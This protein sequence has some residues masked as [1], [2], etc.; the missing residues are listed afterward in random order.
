MRIGSRQTVRSIEDKAMEVLKIPSLLMMDQAGKRVA[1]EIEKRTGPFKGVIVVLAGTGNNGGDGMAAARHLHANGYDVSVFLAGEEKSLSDN[2]KLY[3][4]ILKKSGVP[5]IS[6]V[7]G[8]AFSILEDN[9]RKTDIVVDALA[10]IGLRGSLQPLLKKIIFC[11]NETDALKVAVDIP[12]GVNANTGEADNAFESDVTVTFILPK[13]GL[14][15][16]PGASFAGNIVLDTLSLPKGLMPKEEVD[17]FLIDSRVAEELIMPRRENSHKG[18]HGKTLI[19]AGSKTMPGAALIAAL[20]ALRAGSGLVKLAM[21]K[22]AWMCV[23]YFPEVIPVFL[24]D[25]GSG[26]LNDSGA[27]EIFKEISESDTVAIGPGLTQHSEVK[28]LIKKLI[29]SID[30]PMVI[31][32]DGLNALAGETSKLNEIDYPKVLTPHP[33]EMARL[34][35]VSTAEIQSDRTSYALKAAEKW[36]AVVVLKGAGTVVASPGGRVFINTTGNPGMAAGG[37]GD[38]LTGMIAGLIG[39]GYKEEEAAVLSVYVH[40]KT[41]DELARTKGTMGLTPSET[42]EM[43]PH[44]LHNLARDFLKQEKGLDNGKVY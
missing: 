39:Q 40:G 34:C 1:C 36:Q 8:A 27:E 32:A 9:L 41:A 10:G 12:T 16:Y 13:A 22:T 15:L 19:I 17:M 28:D 30:R 24:E 3:F 44:V 43:I 29:I 37:F 26:L 6:I 31:D 23:S 25:E 11:A 2:G 5:V 21:P 38:V 7:R 33:G 20:G 42:A 14:Y 4:H 35:E 18:Q